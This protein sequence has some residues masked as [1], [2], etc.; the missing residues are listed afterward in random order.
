MASI[1]D[2]P[3]FQLM[4]KVVGKPA[5]SVTK[6]GVGFSKQVLSR[7]GYAHYVLIYI[8]KVD[9]LIGIKACD[10]D[11]PGS[12]RFVPESK[13][14]VDSLRW[15]NPSFKDDIKSLV[16]KDLAEINFVCDGEYLEEEAAL[17][18]DFTKARPLENKVS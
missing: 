10:G 18:F 12:M 9:K 14:R 15:N 16:S 17:L 5:I 3:N 4:E 2:N 6:N 1:F 11:T 8:N 13:E 7:L